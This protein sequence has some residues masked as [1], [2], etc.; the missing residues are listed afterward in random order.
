MDIPKLKSCPFCGGRRLSG[1][2]NETKS[3]VTVC[4]TCESMG[5]S[6]V[7]MSLAAICDAWNTRTPPQV[8]ALVWE[9]ADLACW[10]ETA[11]N[12]M[13]GSYR[14]TWEFGEGPNGED[15]FFTVRFDGVGL[16]SGWSFDADLAMAAAQA[17]YT[18]RIL[19]A[20]T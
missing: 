17:D 6:Q 16:Y 11:Q 3:M 20:L 5:P 18:R 13:G 7:G 8:K 2:R 19:D 12:G 4:D 10:G 14:M 15:T 9:R 1:A